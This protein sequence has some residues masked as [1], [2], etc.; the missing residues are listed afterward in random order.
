MSDTSVKARE[1]YFERLKAM[2][3]S[4]RINLGVALWNAADSVQRAAI[5]RLCPEADEGE[6]TFRLAVSRFGPELARKAYRRT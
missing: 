4:E 3:P 6:I 2:T 1:V 5:L